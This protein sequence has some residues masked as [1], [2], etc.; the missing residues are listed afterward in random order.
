MSRIRGKQIE[1]HTITN[2][3]IYIGLPPLSGTDAVSLSY[4]D[5]ILSGITLSGSSFVG[6]PR[7]GDWATEGGYFQGT[8]ENST[9]IG[10]AFDDVSIVVGKL[11]PTIPPNL[12]TKTLSYPSLYIALTQGTGVSRSNVTYLTQPI[13]TITPSVSPFGVSFSDG[14]TGILSASTDGTLNGSFVLYTGATG[15]NGALTVLTNIDPYSGTSG[16]EG[17]YYSIAATVQAAT[18]YT[19]SNTFHYYGIVHSKTGTANSG[20]GFYVDNPITPSITTIS[21]TMPGSTSRYISGV[22]SLATGQVITASY[23]VLSAVSY[24]YNPTKLAVI[25]SNSIQSSVSSLLPYIVPSIWDSVSYTAQTMTIKTAAYDETFDFTI[26]PYN[27]RDIAGTPSTQ[28]TTVRVDTVSD[29]TIRKTS[30]T[31]QYPTTGYGSTY[32]STKNIGTD[33]GYTQELQMIN[34]SFQYPPSVDYS[35]YGSPTIGPN[36]TG[37]SGTRWATFY[38]LT[39]NNN[40]N[41]QITF[42]TT[43]GSWGSNPIVTGIQIYA[44]VSGVTGWLDC[45]ATYPGGNPINDGDPAMVNDGSSTAT[46]KKLTFGSTATSG[47]LYLRV[48]LPFG[49]NITW[50]TVTYSNVV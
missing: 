48:G 40:K 33:V 11:L 47:P 50:K 18:P 4:L 10:Y 15:S 28:A 19:P 6:A 14:A 16:K 39:L 23:T 13:A 41:V 31:G 24:Y 44:K 22:P 27:S 25:T 7:N 20:T 21:Y 26:T 42:N 3:N 30:S 49:S 5:E 9:P 17:F 12:S 1:T 37:L 8:W 43:S 38:L 36:Y 29:E 2:E 35:T 46:S 45:N 32:D 34:G